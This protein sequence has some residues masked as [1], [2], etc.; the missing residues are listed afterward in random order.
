VGLGGVELVGCQQVVHGVA[1]PAPLHEA[2]RGAAGGV[3]APQRFVLSES[4]VLGGDDDVAGQHH[5]D[6]QRVGVALHGG[7]DRLGA[8][9]AESGRVDPVGGAA[10]FTRAHAVVP[11]G[12]VEAGGEV[13]T[14]GEEHAAPQVVVLVEAGEGLA[15][16]APHVGGETVQLG[17]PVDADEQEALT[18]LGG[19]AALGGVGGGVVGH[20]EVLVLVAARVEARESPAG[21]RTPRC[22]AVVGERRCRVRRRRVRPRGRATSA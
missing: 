15:G 4:G 12:Q 10:P 2:D 13:G 11:L 6:A 1:P 8:S 9:A 22:R 7:D 14:V 20:G 19:D 18:D 17:G 21:G 5:L 16:L 3:D